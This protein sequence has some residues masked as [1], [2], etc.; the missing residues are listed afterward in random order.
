MSVQLQSLLE[1][2]LFFIFIIVNFQLLNSIDY[3]KYFKR[4]RTRH[5]QLVFIFFDIVFS[6]LLT[7]AIM[8]IIIL[9]TNLLK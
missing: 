6:Y 8:N 4:G 9:S 2:C 5:I 1:L 7:R 3:E